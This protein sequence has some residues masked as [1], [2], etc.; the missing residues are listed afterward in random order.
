[1]RYLYASDDRRLYQPVLLRI[2]DDKYPTDCQ[3]DQ[4]VFTNRS[5]VELAEPPQGVVRQRRRSRTCGVMV[6][7]LDTAHPG[8]F[9]Q[10]DRGRWV[11]VCVDHGKFEGHR[12]LE[13]ARM[14]AAQPDIWCEVCRSET[15][16]RRIS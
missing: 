14:F 2:R 9:L 12:T 16:E 8:A 11:T 4:L 7:V 6:E 13:L 5:V 1:V 15:L 3:L 10:S